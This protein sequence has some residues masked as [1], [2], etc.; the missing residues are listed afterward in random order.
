MKVNH[1]TGE[2]RRSSPGRTELQY[3]SQWL[4]LLHLSI[5]G[6]PFRGGWKK[7]AMMLDQKWEAGRSQCSTAMRTPD[8]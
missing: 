2:T 4:S 8:D 3:I 6:S 5:A 7:D 1:C